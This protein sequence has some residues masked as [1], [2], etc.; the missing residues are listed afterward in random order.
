MKMKYAAMLLSMCV[1][2]AIAQVPPG[3]VVPTGY[4]HTDEIPWGSAGAF[5]PGT[6]SKAVFTKDSGVFLDDLIRGM[7]AVKVDPGG[8][9]T[10]TESPKEDLAFFVSKGTGKFTL[11]DE[12][13]DTKPGDAY[14]VPAGTKYGLTNNGNEPVELLMYAAPLIAPNPANKPLKGRADDMDWVPNTTHGPGCEQKMLLRGGFSS[15]I[16]NMWL[17][18]G[19]PGSVNMVHSGGDHQIMY[20]WVAPVPSA[21]PRD[22]RTYGARAILR[23]HIMQVRQ[24][25]AFYAGGA[26]RRDEHG[27][28]DESPKDPLIYIA[29]GALPPGQGPSPGG[30]RRGGRSGAEPGAP[31][32]PGR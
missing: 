9:F 13:I 24:G 16:R 6:S 22:S 8:Q 10:V 1:S 29:I 31:P 7:W 32:P 27:M 21:T 18:K 2:G 28:F 19:N 20:F 14:G 23:D 5:G 3:Y 25:D 30:G 11:G 15:V 26:P 4:V 12:Q 17:M